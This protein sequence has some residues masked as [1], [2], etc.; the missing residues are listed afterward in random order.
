MKNKF[1]IK[2]TSC[3]LL[4]VL[5]FNLV[6]CTKKTK[7]PIERTDFMLGT[8]C[9]IKIYNKS[10]E[11]ILDKGFDKIKDIENK[12]SLNIKESDIYKLY[13]LSGKEPLKVSD[14]TFKVL[15]M[16]KEFGDISNGHFDIT[17]GP[18]SKLWNIG[19]PEAKVPSEDELKET[20][21][22]ID[23]SKLTLDEK[24]K[25]AKLENEGMMVDLGGIAKGYAADEVAKVLKENGVKNAIINLGGNVFTLGKNTNNTEWNIGIQN[26]FEGRGDAVGSVKVENKSIVTSGIYERY[27]EENGKKYHHILNPKTGYPYDNEIAGVTIIT[28][29]SILGDALS[30]TVFSL[31]LHEGLDFINKR[32]D[33]EAIFITKDNKIYLSNGI[34]ENFKLLDNSFTIEN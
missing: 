11:S 4:L 24:N 27:V 29:E 19:T 28:D 6:G 9:S 22:L 7:K 15:K 10:D 26:P 20:L 1:F 17:I 32:K 18:L 8:I 30:T 23:Y 21:P 12:M 34:K 31:G 14:D 3:V 2:F 13:E 16:G 5:L 33:A 25:T